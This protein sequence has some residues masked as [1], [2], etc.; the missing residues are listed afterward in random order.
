MDAADIVL[1]NDEIRFLPFLLRLSR[2]MMHVIRLNLAFSLLLNFAAVLLA[3]RGTLG[4]AAGALIHNA[5]L[6]RSYSTP[7]CCCAG[8]GA[9]RPGFRFRGGRNAQAACTQSSCLIYWGKSREV[10][11]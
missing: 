2:H 8:G 7:P 4:P 5:A 1:V 6:S 3:V 10:T 11:A 9:D